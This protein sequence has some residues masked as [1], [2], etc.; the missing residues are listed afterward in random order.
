MDSEGYG[1]SGK[2]GKYKIVKDQLSWYPGWKWIGEGYGEGYDKEID[3]NK[4]KHNYN[5]INKF[6]FK[7]KT[8]YPK[9]K[10]LSEE[11]VLDDNE[12]ESN[13]FESIPKYLLPLMYRDKLFIFQKIYDNK[14]EDNTGNFN[15]D[16][17]LYFNS[18]CIFA[19]NVCSIVVKDKKIKDIDKSLKKINKKFKKYS[20]NSYT[21]SEDMNESTINNFKKFKLQI[22]R[23][24]K[25]IKYQSYKILWIR[26]CESCTNQIKNT[27]GTAYDIT[28]TMYRTPLCTKQGINESFNKSASLKTLYRRMIKKKMINNIDYYGSI[29]PRSILTTKFITRSMCMTHPKLCKNKKIKRLQYIAETS[30]GGE[31]YKILNIRQ[32][33]HAGSISKYKSDCYVKKINKIFKGIPVDALNIIGFD[34]SNDSKKSIVSIGA[35]DYEKNFKELVFK[36]LKPNTLN[37]IVSHQNYLKGIFKRDYKNNNLTEKLDNNL[38]YDSGSKDVP[39]LNT[40]LLH[41]E[42]DKPSYKFKIF[43]L[44]SYLFSYDNNFGGNPTLIYH[45]LINKT[46]LPSIPS[47]NYLKV[48]EDVGR[49]YVECDFTFK[50]IEK[51]CDIE[52]DLNIENDS[53]HNISP[54]EIVIFKTIFKSLVNSLETDLNDEERVIKPNLFKTKFHR[55]SDINEQLFSETLNEN[56]NEFKH[57]LNQNIMF[58]VELH[59]NLNSDNIK[60]IKTKLE[61]IGFI[62]RIIKEE[63][64]SNKIKVIIPFKIFK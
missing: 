63:S 30:K 12:N 5:I 36:K 31:S 48:S 59:K 2:F 17:T 40:L 20:F 22:D 4:L 14:E 25:K 8:N 26:H 46:D 3:I 57:N 24:C 35:T 41:N 58:E 38:M 56:I 6:E 61:K 42:L 60:H 19:S 28:K 49:K 52:E 13:D 43:N 54:K 33:G 27:L 44:E 32:K 37:V 39:V 29:L 50:E 16:V 21:F 1:E 23:D 62:P 11:E 7:E 18:H 55:I 10:Q 51:D 9:Y 53:N 45:N 34:D 47:V 64:V 15:K